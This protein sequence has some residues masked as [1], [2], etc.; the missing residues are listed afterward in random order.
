V[1]AEVA[2]ADDPRAAAEAHRGTDTSGRTF[3]ILVETVPPA[4]REGELAEEYAA[5]LFSL[6]E[7]GV[8]PELAHTRF[9]WH[10][11]VLTELVPPWSIPADEAERVVRRQ[12][13]AEARALALDAL[14]TE[15]LAA[16]PVTIDPVGLDLALR[17]PL[18]GM[19]GAPGAAAP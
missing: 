13:A 16:T 4:R 11:V 1:L 7:P 18:G 14:G 5:S 19:P 9:G 15:L 6:S 3:Q 17:A 2:A 8:V 12:M 10:V